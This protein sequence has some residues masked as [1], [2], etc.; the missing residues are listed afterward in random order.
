MKSFWLLTHRQVCECMVNYMTDSHIALHVTSLDVSKAA[1]NELLT[2]STPAV[3]SCCCSK[4]LPHDTGLTYHFKF[5]TFGRSGA[6][7]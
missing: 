5:L 3:P 1:D 4:G 7:P 6:Q 2:P